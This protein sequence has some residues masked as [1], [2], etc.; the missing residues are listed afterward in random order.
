MT[1]TFPDVLAAAV[2]AICVALVIR[3]AIKS[4]REASRFRPPP[5]TVDIA[6]APRSANPNV[7]REVKEYPLTRTHPG[8]ASATTARPQGG[9]GD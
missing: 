6:P 9:G 5:F 7:R 3:K 1:I 2:I 8:P 4:S